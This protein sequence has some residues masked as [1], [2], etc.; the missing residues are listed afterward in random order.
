MRSDV[1]F[2]MSDRVLIA[3]SWVFSRKKRNNIIIF[4][5]YFTYGCAATAYE[6][7]LASRYTLDPV[8]LPVVLLVI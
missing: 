4:D 1:V 3:R 6:P 2:G 5:N 7:L 8:S